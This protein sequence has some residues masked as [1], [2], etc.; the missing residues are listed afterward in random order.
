M[1]RMFLLRYHIVLLTHSQRFGGIVGTI[2][3]NSGKVILM[4]SLYLQG[5]RHMFQMWY[6]S[7]L[8]G[9]LSLIDMKRMFQ[10]RFDRVLLMYSQNLEDKSHRFLMLYHIIILKY[11]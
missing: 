10:L 2:L 6:Y 4:S 8:L 9:N 11:S 1:S 3:I 7:C 5:K